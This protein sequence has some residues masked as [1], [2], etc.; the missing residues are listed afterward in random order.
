MSSFYNKKKFFP[1][2]NYKSSLTNQGVRGVGGD[3]GVDGDRGDEVIVPRKYLIIVE[4]PS[5]CKKIEDFLGDDYCCIASKGHL[6]EIK[7]L[8]SINTKDN[9][10]IT[11]SI[12]KD[13]EKH[14]Q[15]M[16]QHIDLYH[17]NNIFLATDHDREGEAIAWHI[18]EIFHL[19]VDSIK[20]IT[21]NEITYSAISLSLSHHT[22]INSHLVYAQH[23]RLLLDLFVGFFIS[24]S[25]NIHDIQ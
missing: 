11:F 13:K 5:K 25:N 19:P 21:F 1:K 9:F 2:N 20:R 3:K 24:L 18:C 23:A 16:K 15:Y 12:I 22:L 6:R 8:K 17:I 10:E 4:S 14:I 7:G